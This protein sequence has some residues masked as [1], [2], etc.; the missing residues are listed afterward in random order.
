MPVRTVNA[1]THLLESLKHVPLPLKAISCNAHLQQLLPLA[2]QK[3]VLMSLCNADA[4]HSIMED[5]G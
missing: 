2:F 1:C 4:K 5:S 3:L